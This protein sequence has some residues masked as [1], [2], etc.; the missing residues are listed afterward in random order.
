MSVFGFQ[1]LWLDL[2]VTV[3]V[4]EYGF[5][6]RRADAPGTTRSM[7]TALADL[8]VKHL[9]VIYPGEEQYQLDESITALPILS[10]PD[11]A[12]ELGVGAE[13]LRFVS[14]RVKLRTCRS[15]GDTRIRMNAPP[16]GLCS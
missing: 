12:R 13:A 14:C 8:D 1:G 5:E 4:R 3:R 2:L 10:L 9:W 15:M 16:Y 11:A 7:R 6:F